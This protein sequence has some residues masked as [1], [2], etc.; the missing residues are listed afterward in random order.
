VKLPGMTAADYDAVNGQIEKEGRPAGLLSHAAGP[1]ED[2][3]GVIDIWESRE[4]FDAFAGS[5][6][7]SAMSAMDN[8]PQPDIKQFEVHNFEIGAGAGA[9][10]AK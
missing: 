9:Y 1:I 4:Q 8:P 10:A 7:A 3:W 5:Q 2:G 6:L